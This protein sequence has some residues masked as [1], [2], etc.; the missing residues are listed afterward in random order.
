MDKTEKREMLS[1]YKNEANRSSVIHR[2]QN[3]Q[4]RSDPDP[5][6]G[7]DLINKVYTS[8]MQINSI[9]VTYYLPLQTYTTSGFEILGS[10]SRSGN[11]S[12]TTEHR[13]F[14]RA[15]RC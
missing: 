7:P 10:R 15:T 11:Q 2:S 5:D 12:R 14:L 4:L 6:P 8:T 9:V 13:G 3:L 1:N